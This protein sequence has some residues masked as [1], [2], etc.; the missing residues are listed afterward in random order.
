MSLERAHGAF[1]TPA[2]RT[3]DVSLHEYGAERTFTLHN[4]VNGVSW[5][6]RCRTASSQARQF[7]DM[8]KK[9]SQVPLHDLG[10]AV[11]TATG[12]IPT[13]SETVEK[14]QPRK[15]TKSTEIKQK[16]ARQLSS[17]A[18]PV[19]AHDG[20]R[21]ALNTPEEADDY[22]LK[23]W[24]TKRNAGKLSWDEDF[25]SEMLRLCEEHELTYINPFAL[26]YK[27]DAVSEYD[28]AQWR[29]LVELWEKIEDEAEKLSVQ[30]EVEKAGKK[31]SSPKVLEVLELCVSVDYV[32]FRHGWYIVSV[33]TTMLPVLIAMLVAEDQ[34]S[35]FIC[36]CRFTKQRQRGTS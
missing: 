12:T 14:V 8:R 34:R 7:G 15:Q 13:G 17:R 28:A 30:R 18:L 24:K 27:E 33:C 35:R 26:M 22:V 5:R 20:I 2:R 10:K 36:R 1:D 19:A 31:N 32:W 11:A 4:S 25:K 6:L 29:F 23:E 16:K 21:P 9:A 3:R